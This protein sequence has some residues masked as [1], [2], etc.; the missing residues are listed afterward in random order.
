MTLEIEVLPPVSLG[1]MDSGEL[2]VIPFG[3]GSFSGPELT[4]V[5]LPGGSDWQEVRPDGAL[6]IR[7]HYLLETDRGERIEVRSEGV[8]SGS[9]AALARLAAGELLPAA[10]YYFRTAIR[11]RTAST[12]LT[13]L[14]GLLAFSIGERRPS[15]VRLSVFELL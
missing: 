8:R 11:L 10:E 7:A 12:R 4:G 6:E 3:S 13:R 1:R 14:N 9:A 2:R 15:S 5:L